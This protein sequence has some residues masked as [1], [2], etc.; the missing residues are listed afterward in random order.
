MG[1]AP[2]N[3]KDARGNR[4]TLSSQLHFFERDGVLG[5]DV[6]LDD[7]PYHGK[8]VVPADRAEMYLLCDMFACKVA[9]CDERGSSR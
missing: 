6:A 3:V 5:P 7:A 4:Y 9:E 1:Y 8:N 2:V